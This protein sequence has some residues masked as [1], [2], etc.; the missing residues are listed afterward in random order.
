MTTTEL[1]S[2]KKAELVELASNLESHNAD[3]LSRIEELKSKASQASGR[4]SL[5]SGHYVLPD[6]LSVTLQS[7]SSKAGNVRKDCQARLR[8]AGSAPLQAEFDSI[9]SA[10]F[11]PRMLR[12]AKQAGLTVNKDTEKQLQSAFKLKQ[13]LIDLG[14]VRSK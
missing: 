14:L 10:P 6:E 12:I 5:E 11:N 4:I 2:L 13:A 7:I 1:N 8:E 3:L 9:G